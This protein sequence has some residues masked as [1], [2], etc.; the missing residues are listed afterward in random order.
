MVFPTTDLEPESEQAFELEPESEQEMEVEVESEQMIDPELNP[1][2]CMTTAQ[3]RRFLAN[4]PAGSLVEVTY[5]GCNGT[6]MQTANGFISQ[7]NGSEL[8]LI[9]ARTGLPILRLQANMICG[10]N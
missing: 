3:I 6:A 2:T 5:M 9:P 7:F 1:L 8:V 4:T 10:L